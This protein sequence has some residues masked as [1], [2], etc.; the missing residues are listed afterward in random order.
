MPM[1]KD[2][3]VG[4]LGRMLRLFFVPSEKDVFLISFP[5]SGNSWLRSAIA[6]M[7]FGQSGARLEDIH[8][9][10]PTVGL[11][12]PK[13]RMKPS[14]FHVV[15]THEMRLI[16]SRTD[17]YTDFIY[18]VRDPRDAVLSH[19]RFYSQLEKWTQG[20]DGFFDHWINGRVWL[21]SWVQHV[22][23]WIGGSDLPRSGRRLLIKYEDLSRDVF[24]EFRRVSD[25]LGLSLDDHQLERAVD[26]TSI[27]RMRSKEE[28]NSSSPKGFRSIQDGGTKK[29]GSTLSGQQLQQIFRSCGEVMQ[30]LGYV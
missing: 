11:N 25:F 14:S 13:W 2:P 29:W 6:E 27:H 7:M 10:V 22:T 12:L 20:F 18:V 30:W 4:K 23:S 21:G 15:K 24:G 3:A 26:E 28:R 8:Y 1:M 9:Y 17:H 19:F 16:N 5:R